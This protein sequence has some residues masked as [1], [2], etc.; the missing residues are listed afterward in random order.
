MLNAEKI[1]SIVAGLASIAGLVL[2][3]MFEHP[4]K[5]WIGVAFLVLMAG[6]VAYQVLR[7]LDHVIKLKYPHGYTKLAS[8][9][10]Y[11]CFDGKSIEYSIHKL[12]QA[13]TPLLRSIEHNF[14]WSGTN[15]PTVDCAPHKLS[16][17][18]YLGSEFDWDK[19][20]IQLSETILYNQ[21]VVIPIKMVIDDCDQ[22]SGPYVSHRVDE[23]SQLISWRVELGVNK[24]RSGMPAQLCRK[25]VHSEHDSAWELLWLVNY[26][27]IKQSYE[28]EIICPKMGY[29]YR[30]SWDR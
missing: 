17:I 30:L 14:K 9:A 7:A 27:S 13:K 29:H 20:R 2:Y 11:S 18:D 21:V 4:M 19:V 5:G 15:R 25:P 24:D 10:R 22:K 6:Y 8:F 3:L 16:G 1:F 26:H 28:T 12:I 23:P